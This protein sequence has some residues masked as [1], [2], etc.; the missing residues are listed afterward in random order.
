MSDKR[1]YVAH[2]A[3]SL[4]NGKWLTNVDSE[5]TY[6]FKV[7]YDKKT[8]DVLVHKETLKYMLNIFHD[9]LD[10]TEK[11][12][13]ERDF[14]IVNKYVRKEEFCDFLKIVRQKM[15]K[16]DRIIVGK[17]NDYV[18][19]IEYLNHVYLNFM[20]FCRHIKDTRKK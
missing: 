15:K 5:P 12:D 1:Y 18:L 10:L 14:K 11:I 20:N 19:H 2:F 17:L 4:E 16:P 7:Y 8:A 9:Y 6:K 13:I 3:V